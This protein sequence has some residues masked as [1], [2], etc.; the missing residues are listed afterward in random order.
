MTSQILMR[1]CLGIELSCI[2]LFQ[3][4][5][6]SLFFNAVFFCTYENNIPVAIQ[7][8]SS[9]KTKPEAPF[10][11]PDLGDDAG[12]GVGLSYW[13][14]SLCSLV[15]RYDNPMPES[16]IYPNQGLRTWLLKYLCRLQNY[17]QEIHFSCVCKKSH[18]KR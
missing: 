17:V 15:C 7:K 6:F 13:H 5:G 8:K 10:L 16:T 9:D 4:K 2:F 3:L 14:V 1:M 18:R 12:Y 11:F